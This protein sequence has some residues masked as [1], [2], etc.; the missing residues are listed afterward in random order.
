MRPSG[1]AGRSLALAL[2][3]VVLAGVVAGCGG[4]DDAA[5]TASP[6]PSTGSSSPSSTAPAPGLSGASTQPVSKRSTSSTTS[7]LREA[8]LAG[9][10]GYDRFVLQFSGPVPGY[11]VRYVARPITED[12]SDRP[13]ALEGGSVLRIRLE[14]AST[15]DLASADAVVTYTGSKRLRADTEAVTEAAL[16]GDFEAVMTWVLGVDGRQPFRVTEL[17]GPSRLVIDISTAAG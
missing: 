2:A 3:G 1:I 15:V 9:Q 12:P 7:L 5:P 14:P 11:D 17:S 8:R 16:I 4:S 6:A 10:E 13:V